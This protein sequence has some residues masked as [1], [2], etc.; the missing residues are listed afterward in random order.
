MYIITDHDSVVF[1]VSKTL[2]YQENGNPL[3]DNGTLAIAK[4]LVAEIYES[5]TIPNDYEDMKYLY[6]GKEWSLNPYRPV[7]D[8]VTWEAM[9]AAITEGVNE[10]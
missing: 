3:V 7:S 4:Y 2:G 6:D 5:D 9:A 1:H 8:D 10:V